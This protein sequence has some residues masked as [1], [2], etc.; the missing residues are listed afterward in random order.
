[1]THRVW[2]LFGVAGALMF[3]ALSC[4]PFEPAPRLQTFVLPGPHAALDCAACH[5]DEPPYD[6]IVWDLDCVSCHDAGTEKQELGD[7]NGLQ[8]GASHYVPTSQ[9]TCSSNG[10]CHK[11]VDPDWAAA[12]GACGGTVDHSFLPLEGTHALGCTECHTGASCETFSG[13]DLVNLQDVP[14]TDPPS[15]CMACHEYE[16]TGYDPNHYVEDAADRPAGAELRWDCK[17]CHDPQS[18]DGD[19]TVTNGFAIY[20]NPHGDPD[21]RV[22]HGTFGGVGYG[23]L[24]AALPPDQWVTECVDCHPAGEPVIDTTYQC[25]VACHVELFE[26]TGEH[27]D[28]LPGEDAACT[29]CHP[30]AQDTI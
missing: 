29:A 25:T 14:I 16:R 28:Y 11:D 30:G 6:P 22:P 8:W 2:H 21:I 24:D 5:F 1:M 3:G 10:G 20:Q 4:A 27:Q 23:S 9:T 15:L 12:A 18:R 7:P 17:A 13:L 19:A 26:A